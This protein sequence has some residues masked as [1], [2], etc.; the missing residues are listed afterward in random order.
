[1]N[2]K[3]LI[4]VGILC[5]NL[6]NLYSQETKARIENVD[7]FVIDEQIMISYDLVK[8]SSQETFNLSVECVTEENE[9]IIPTSLTGDI[10]EGVKPGKGKKVYWD[11]FKDLDEI[12]GEIM[13]RINIISVERIYGGPGNAAYSLLVPGLGDYYV[14]DPAGM[15]IKPYYRTIAAY[16]LVG[17]GLIER[18][19]ANNK[20]DDYNNSTNRDEF[21]DLYDKANKANH[22]SQIAIGMGVAVWTF[23]VVW[24]IIKGAK[25]NKE[26]KY[27]FQGNVDG[28]LMLGYDEHGVN[29]KYVFKF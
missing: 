2:W 7:F 6:A 18:I 8:A 25:N 20:Y 16:G 14:A 27:R 3:S 17:Y 13:F 19:N 24:V 21:D 11:V 9:I 26:N 10:G 28:G 1:M 5:A 4:L 23:D 12:S 22:R 29:V 15:K